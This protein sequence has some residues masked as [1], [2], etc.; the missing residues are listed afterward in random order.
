MPTANLSDDDKADM[1]LKASEALKGC[2]LINQSDKIRY[3]RLIEE[4]QNY[5]MKGHNNYPDTLVRAFQMLNE[6]RHWKPSSNVP[7]SQS[8][9]FVQKINSSTKPNNSNNNNSGSNGNNT[10]SNNSKVKCFNCGEEWQ[11]WRECTKKFQGGGTTED[12][13]SQ[14]SKKTSLLKLQPT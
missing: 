14:E 12:D 13:T 2:A 8:V 9:A 7:E 6:Y 4:L 3:G 11:P 5:Y 10:K 1:H